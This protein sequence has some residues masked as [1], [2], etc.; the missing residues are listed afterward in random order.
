MTVR[1]SKPEFNLREKLTELDFDRVPYQKMPAGSVIQVR[2]NIIT[3]ASNNNTASNNFWN[4]SVSVAIAPTRSDSKILISGHVCCSVAG[5]QYNIGVGI[6]RDGSII[7]GAR[8]DAASNRSR[9]LASG[10]MN[11]SENQME[12]IPF[13]YMDTA[14][15]INSRTYS[16]AIFNPSSITRQIYLNRGVSDTDQSYYTRGASVITVME[17]S[18]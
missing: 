9:V 6:Y 17:V 11:H 16:I 15:N 5:P 2:N 10:A 1:I 18:G 8:G 13:N 7:D 12:S 4:T 14:D 3:S